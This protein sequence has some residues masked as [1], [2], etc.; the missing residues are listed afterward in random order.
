[1]KTILTIAGYDPSS[2]AGVTKDLDTFFSQGFHGLSVPTSIVVQGPHGVRDIYPIP[3]EQFVSMLKVIEDETPVDGVK[4]GV[5]W[6]SPYVES[7]VRY[8]KK[9]GRK[10]IVVDPICMAKNGK[11]LITERGLKSLVKKIFPMATVLTP[12]VEEASLITGRSIK[13]LDDAK[14]C[15]KVL[16]GLGLQGIV[17]KG[18]HLERDPVDV[19]YDGKDIT[20]WEKPRINRE[21]HGTGCAFSSLFTVFL[22]NGYSL[23]EAFLATEK[24]MRVIL[25]ESYPIAHGG[26]YYSSSG[27]VR[28]Y[29]AERWVVLNSLQEA[30]RRLFELNP[31]ELIPE[32]QMNIG[33][34]ISKVKGIEDVAAFPGRISHCGGKILFKGEPR[35]GA[36]S[37]VARLILAMMKHYPYMRA[38]VNIRYDESYIEKAQKRGLKIIF[39]DRRKEP[40]R[41]KSSEGRSLDFLMEGVLK[42]VKH[43][44]DFIYDRGDVGK[45]P[46]IRCFARDPMELIEKMEKI[47]L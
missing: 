45:E 43:P 18:G 4:I 22:V 7:I 26:Y 3:E 11:R 16:T 25:E 37:H 29:D 32:V 30:K 19:F 31:V 13:T 20:L 47:L 23:K 34:A 5:V 1:M 44:P 8:L 33:Y 2:G 15:A 39:F 42:R 41:I 10:P 21:V 9:L 40:G 24:E 12:N 38:C 27:I 35:F 36:S 14:D 28:A 6:D 46:I 17:V